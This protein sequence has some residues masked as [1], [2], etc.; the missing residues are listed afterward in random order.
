MLEEVEEGS[1][2]TEEIERPLEESEVGPTSID[3]TDEQDFTVET[4][5]AEQQEEEVQELNKQIE[6]AQEESKVSKRKQKRRITSYLSSISK[7]VE[8]QGNQINKT[9]LMIQSLQKQKQTKPTV[10]ARIDRSQSEFIKQIK[11]Q[12][13]QLHRQI[14]QIQNDVLRIRTVSITGKRQGSRTKV[15]KQALL[16]LLNRGLRE[17]SHIEVFNLGNLN[18]LPEIDLRNLNHNNN[19]DDNWPNIAGLITGYWI[20]SVNNM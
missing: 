11:Y 2:M 12:I 17:P 4:P 9:I 5:P 18:A 16:L 10:N 3:V 7:Q 13:N 15:R 20:W 19:A 8:K 14:A 6:Q 1:I